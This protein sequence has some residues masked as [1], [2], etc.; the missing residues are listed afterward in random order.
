MLTKN[1]TM[2]HDFIAGSIVINLD[3]TVVI[4]SLDERKQRIEE[5][6]LARESYSAISYADVKNRTKTWE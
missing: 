2:I 6:R 1:R 5:E 4:D 3:T